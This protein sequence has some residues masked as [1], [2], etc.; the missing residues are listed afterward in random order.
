MQIFE[1]PKNIRSRRKSLEK[2]VFNT[3]RLLEA[4]FVPVITFENSLDPDKDRQ[5][6]GV[7]PDGSN[8][9]TL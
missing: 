3:L 1:K 4:T 2:N 5:N 7:G 9:L 8:R 6:V